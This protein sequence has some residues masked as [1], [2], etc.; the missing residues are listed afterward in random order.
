[1]EIT[2]RDIIIAILVITNIYFIINNG[3]TVKEE[4]A[5]IPGQTSRPEIH[6]FTPVNQALRQ[7][8][9]STGQ[10]PNIFKV[11]HVAQGT[12][13]EQPRGSVQEQRTNNTLW[14]T[15]GS[16]NRDYTKYPR[17]N[18]F[19]F[20]FPYKIW[21]VQHVE[22]MKANIPKGQYTIDFFNTWTDIL[23]NTTTIVSIQVP[24]GIYDI[25]SYIVAFNASLAAAA[26]G[27]TA[28][29]STV[30][31]SVTLTNTSG[32]NNYTLLYKTGEHQDFSNFNEIGFPP[33]DTAINIGNSFT[34]SRVTL[35]GTCCI[36][37][38]LKEVHYSNDSDILS[39]VVLTSGSI[40]HFQS[41]YLLSKR[42]INPYVSL[43]QLTVEVTFT[44]PFKS[45]K[46]YNFNG[47]DFDFTIEIMTADYAIPF[48]SKLQNFNIP[49][50]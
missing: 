3:T 36:D 50:I 9:T 40:T 19:R 32:V 12:G 13:M 30:T 39:T 14:F 25:A 49:Y 20:L 8:R 28:T 7:L 26:I 5:S 21:N 31:E 2:H 46:Y 48:L 34:G 23:V 29:Y 45:E 16:G 11:P 47:L 44:Q 1:M 43:S 6:N 33:V 22:L 38:H 17:A 4:F 35:F 27:L 24:V 42:T 37:I 15:I 10:S 18:Q 41:P